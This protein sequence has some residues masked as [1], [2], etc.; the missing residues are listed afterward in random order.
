MVRAGAFPALRLPPRTVV[1]GSSP[2]GGG[3]GNRNIVNSQGQGM[4]P[5]APATFNFANQIADSGWSYTE[6]SGAQRGN[7][8]QQPVGG[9]FAYDAENRQVA[10]CP[11]DASPA[12]CTATAGNGRTLYFYDGQGRR[13]M[14]QAP[15][16]TS[17]EFVY[18]TAGN[19]SAEYDSETSGA[20]PCTT[21]YVTTDHLGST[22]VVTDSTG[23]AVFRQDYIPFG[24]T[25]LAT[26]GNPRLSATGGTVCATNGYVAS[27]SPVR[28]QFTGEER[29][30]ETGNDF[31]QAR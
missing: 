28:M 20:A 8:A 13:V 26:S 2:G 7:V 14:R 10:Y 23:C 6:G 27:A 15:D 17:S 3:S 21:C 29:D 24:E 19:L 11:N 22:R 16:G 5:L 4:S 12:T 1:A 30:A 9:T 25:V 18:D 31:F